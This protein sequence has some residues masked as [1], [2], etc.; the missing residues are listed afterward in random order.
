M[1]DVLITVAQILG[2]SLIVFMCY[3][4]IGILLALDHPKPI[5]MIF[6]WPKMKWQEWR[7]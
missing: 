3:I 6:F 4:L 5:D 7:R 2:I 1:F